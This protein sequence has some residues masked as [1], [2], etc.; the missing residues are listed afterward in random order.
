ML[1]CWFGTTFGLASRLTLGCGAWGRKKQRVTESLVN[2]RSVYNVTWYSFPP[3]S[4]GIHS[5]KCYLA[6]ALLLSGKSHA[7]TQFATD[8]TW[9]G[10]A[11]IG[12]GVGAYVREILL[13]VEDEQGSDGVFF[14]SLPRSCI[15]RWRLQN[16]ST[17]W[18]HWW[19]TP[20][21]SL[22]AL[23]PS[24]SSFCLSSRSTSRQAKS[25][26]WLAHVWTSARQK[27]WRLLGGTNMPS[28]QTWHRSVHLHRE[29]LIT[30]VYVYMF[31]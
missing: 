26:N 14:V 19:R 22:G 15:A 2:I 29:S 17:G 27:R 31:P 25:W 5:E 4:K 23:R 16:P 12:E 28:Y 1:A 9:K 7:L 13:K 8:F 20:G 18:R 6:A 11:R 24:S 10:L 21:V 30:F 3:L